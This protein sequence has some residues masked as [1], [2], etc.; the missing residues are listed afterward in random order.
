MPPSGWGLAGWWPASDRWH[1][2]GFF[3]P[4]ARPIPSWFASWVSVS[5]RKRRVS[6]AWKNGC[7]KSLASAWKPRS[8]SI[9]CACGCTSWKASCITTVSRCRPMMTAIKALLTLLLAAVIGLLWY[10]GQAANAVAKQETVEA[11]M[12]TLQAE[13]DALAAALEHS[14]QHALAMESA[15]QK[16]EQEK[17]DAEQ[18]AEKL[19]ADLRTGAVRLRERWQ[20]CPASPSVPAASAAASIADAGAADR[21]ESAARI[22]RAAAECDAQVRGLQAV[23]RADRGE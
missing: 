1:G 4:K 2:S 5:R 15:A 18:R 22:V 13:R 9:A 11:Q 20:G 6:S 21:S 12:Q 8:A 10:R 17:Q 19:A 3:R 7:T 16:Y 14:H 23:I